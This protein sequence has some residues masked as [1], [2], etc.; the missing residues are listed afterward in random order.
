MRKLARFKY[1]ADIDGRNE[2]VRHLDADDGDL[3]G[4]GGDAHAACAERKGNIVLQVGDLRELHALA[5]REFV[6][7]DRRAAHHIARLSVHAEARERLRQAAGVV[8]RSAP[9]SAAFVTALFQR[10]MGGYS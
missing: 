9:A 3:V 6:A 5:E 4:N 2:L 1:R 7:R 10:V 8:A